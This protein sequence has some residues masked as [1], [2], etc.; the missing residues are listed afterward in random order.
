MRLYWSICHIIIA[1]F[2]LANAA[3]SLALTSLSHLLLYDSF[4]AIVCGMVDVFSNFEVWKTSSIRHPFGLERA[5]VLAGFAMSVLL[6]FMGMDLIS[7]NAQHILEG[8]GSHEAHHSHAA[9]TEIPRHALNAS[10]FFA[11]L[12]TTVSARILDNHARIGKVLRLGYFSNLPSIL[13]N[14]SHFLTITCS[15]CLLLL[16]HT[17]IDLYKYM[18]HVLS[19]TIAICMSG[20]GFRIVTKLGKMLLMT[21]SPSANHAISETASASLVELVSTIESD[22]L[23]SRVEEAKVW[24]VHY[25]LCMANFK[26]RVRGEE[27]NFTRLKD[28]L[29]SLVKNKLGGGYGSGSGVR[30]EVTAQLE[31]EK[32][33]AV[34]KTR[35]N[36]SG[37]R[38]HSG[39]GIVA[40]GPG[41]EKADGKAL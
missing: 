34:L 30:W 5:E 8:A 16:S 10:A 14:P 12:A 6:I 35:V 15:F 37:G 3:G 29:T 40:L 20:F 4:G 2:T 27:E 25:G 19:C 23:V 13:S 1:G 22:P 7:H 39:L 11:I 31:R 38:S 21:W 33:G 28:R 32:I 26:L 24:Q 17:T 9:H 41:S 36:G 18:D